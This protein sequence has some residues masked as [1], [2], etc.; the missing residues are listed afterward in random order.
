MMEQIAMKEKMEGAPDERGRSPGGVSQMSSMS[1]CLLVYFP[2]PSLLPTTPTRN[3]RSSTTTVLLY[4]DLYANLQLLH[5]VLFLR[6]A[7]LSSLPQTHLTNHPD[8]SRK[9]A[10]ASSPS[11]KT[12]A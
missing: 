11:R 8:P 3:L 4:W 12:V 6:I 5:A 10:Q 7:N 1:V 2:S 9:S